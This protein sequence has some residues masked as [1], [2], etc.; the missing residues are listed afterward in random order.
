MECWF[1]LNTTKTEHKLKLSLGV[2]TALGLPVGDFKEHDGFAARSAVRL[3][4]AEKAHALELDD[5]PL[6]HG[7]QAGVDDCRGLCARHLVEVVLELVAV[8]ELVLADEVVEIHD[9]RGDGVGLRVGCVRGVEEVSRERLGIGGG[10]ARRRGKE[11]G[12]EEATGKFVGAPNSPTASRKGQQRAKRSLGGSGSTVEAAGQ[13]AAR[14]QTM[15]RAEQM[16]S[17]ER[18]KEWERKRE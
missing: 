9:E 10:R 12:I 5:G 17:G 8:F 16:S 14:K 18:T 3:V 7:A 2:G 15:S 4:D 13:T 11:R 1:S 6:W